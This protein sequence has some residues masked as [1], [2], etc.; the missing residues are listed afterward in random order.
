MAKNNFPRLVRTRRTN[1]EDADD[2]ALLPMKRAGQQYLWPC[3]TRTRTFEIVLHSPLEAEP[4][5]RNKS[6][7]KQR[8]ARDKYR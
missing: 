2:A 4:R 3:S 8:P 6:H 7:R 1:D 5:N